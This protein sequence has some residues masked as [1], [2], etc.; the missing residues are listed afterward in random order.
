MTRTKK[1]AG[2]LRARF[3]K[4]DPRPIAADRSVKGSRG[5]EHQHVVSVTFSIDP[6]SSIPTELG[7][8]DGR[9][10]IQCR[11]ESDGSIR[12]DLLGRW[13][14][15]AVRERP[16]ELLERLRTVGRPEAQWDLR[17]IKDL[18]AA[19]A[20]L[21][22]H[23]WNRIRPHNLWLRSEDAWVLDTLG[24]LPE[25]GPVDS[26]N[27][28]THRKLL[29]GVIDTLAAT[30]DIIAMLGAV[31]IDIV[32]LLGSFRDIPGREITATIFRSGAQAIA[33]SGLVGFLIGIVLSYLSGEQLRDIGAESYVVNLTGFAVLRELGP[34][35]AAVLNAGRS[36]SAMTAQ[37]GLMRVTGELD[38]MSV[39]G[40]SHV[41]RLV[42]PKAIG[43]LVALP[44]VVVWVD[45]TAIIGGMFG[46][47]LQLGIAFRAFLHRLVQL[48]P[49]SNVWFGVGKGAL[50]GLLVALI[51]C[52]FGFG[53][54][55]DTES[56]SA[57]TTRAVVTALTAVLLIDAVLA[58]AFSHLGM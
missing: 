40:I 35:L 2:V 1:Y 23:A 57:G 32:A 56:L 11:V 14:I 4:G 46:A 6:R 5:H 50:F 3:K 34:M 42:V 51:S 19:G 36:G 18:D 22:W 53:I 55:P 58:V 45:L 9:S 52:H 12:I 31:T 13:D 26:A 47:R 7:R 15:R 38:A 8:A 21:I 29:R 24:A 41:R 44:L 25:D 48:V 39:L 27:A 33:I 16:Q 54:R 10:T 17:Q 37:I 43:Q 28:G 30:V 20:T 49:L